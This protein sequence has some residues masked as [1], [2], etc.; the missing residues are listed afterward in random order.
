MDIRTNRAMK[1]LI[2]IS[3]LDLNSIILDLELVEII[4]DGVIN[5]NDL[6]L[7][8]ARVP[9]SFDHDSVINRYFDK[10]ELECSVNHIHIG[11]IVKNDNILLQGVKYA[12]ELSE[13]LE[14]L[15]EFE[16]ILSYSDHPIGDCSVRF[17]KVRFDEAPYLLDLEGY[18]EAL[19][20]IS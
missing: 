6:Y 7:L 12:S 1:K 11:D 16:I 20:I 19:L 8:R 17:H 9:D 13:L 18:Q 2:D 14:K 3:A 5:I 4:R 10:T 15:G